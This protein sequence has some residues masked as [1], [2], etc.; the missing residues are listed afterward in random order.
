MLPLKGKNQGKSTKAQLEFPEFSKQEI[1]NLLM[2]H[3]NFESFDGTLTSL[4]SLLLALPPFPPLPG[5]VGTGCCPNPFSRL[6]SDESGKGALFAAQ[7]LFWVLSG[8]GCRSSVVTINSRHSIANQ[9]PWARYLNSRGCADLPL[10]TTNHGRRTTSTD[11]WFRASLPT[12]WRSTL[13]KP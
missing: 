7:K 2:F 4:R 5:Q 8:V 9:M 10:Y 11:S 6:L 1:S 3:D 12:S 13:A